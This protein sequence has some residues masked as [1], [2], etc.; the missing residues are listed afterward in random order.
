MKN[1]EVRGMKG[2]KTGRSREGKD[3]DLRNEVKNKVGSKRKSKV[4]PG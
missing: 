1:D 3:D 2:D 4:K